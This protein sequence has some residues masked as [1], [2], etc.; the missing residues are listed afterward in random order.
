MIE[1]LHGCYQND[2][3]DDETFRRGSQYHG[4]A[5]GLAD[6]DAIDE[7]GHDELVNT[8]VMEAL[9]M[10]FLAL[11]IL[12]HWDILSQISNHHYKSIVSP[13]R[14]AIVLMAVVSIR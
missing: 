8:L 3:N 14:P 10:A 1:L 6:S 11:G 4:N 9:V 12:F 2:L 5:N 7:N 13:E